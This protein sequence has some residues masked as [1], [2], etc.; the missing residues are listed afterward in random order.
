MADV[1]VVIVADTV[2]WRIG[3]FQF[4]RGAALLPAWG[5][6]VV[7][8]LLELRFIHMPEVP[9]VVHEVPPEADVDPESG[10]S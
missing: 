7:N 9:Q 2:G 6:D 10:I 5:A 4:C 3:L 1:L 8:C